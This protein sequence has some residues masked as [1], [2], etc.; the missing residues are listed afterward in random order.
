MASNKPLFTVHMRDADLTT[1]E[2]SKQIGPSFLKIRVNQ[3][4]NQSTF[5]KINSDN[6]K[7]KELLLGKAKW[8]L[9]GDPTKS[10][11]KLSICDGILIM[12]FEFTGDGTKKDYEVKAPFKSESDKP[13]SDKSDGHSYR[14]GLCNVL[15]EV[16]RDPGSDFATEAVE[17]DINALNSADAASLFQY[18]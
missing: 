5:V 8:T 7:A 15:L 17:F 4:S 11:V 13:K 9:K 18:A 2:K 14:K 10:T 6:S 16:S 12:N 3:R 1:E